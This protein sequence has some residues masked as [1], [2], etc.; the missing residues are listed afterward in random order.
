MI[1]T[2]LIGQGYWGKKIEDK[3]LQLSEIQF[4][5]TSVSYNPKFFTT[6]DWVFIATPAYTHSSIVKDCITQGV[7]VFVE[8]P[9]CS[10]SLEAQELIALANENQTNLYVDNIFLSRSELANVKN[11]QCKTIKF[12]WHKNGPFNDNLIN[13]LLYH[14]LYILINIVGYKTISS[15]QFKV[16]EKDILAFEFYYGDSKVEI[17]YNRVSLDKKEKIIYLDN[18]IINFINHDE[19]PLKVIIENCLQKKIDFESNHLLNLQTTAL[20]EIVKQHINYFKNIH[21]T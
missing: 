4:I 15:L 1:K 11:L 10:T 2:G 5:Q 16:N 19:D 17:D 14:D 9:F 12:R 21:E 20:M 7:N 8:K 6:V 13:D 18:K 3:L